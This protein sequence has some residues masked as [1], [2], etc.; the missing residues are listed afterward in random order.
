MM[1]TL[2]HVHAC[3]IELGDRVSLPAMYPVGVL[4]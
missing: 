4:R 3:E 1:R 2:I